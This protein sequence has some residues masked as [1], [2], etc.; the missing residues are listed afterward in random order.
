[1]VVVHPRR[2]GQLMGAGKSL[3]IKNE[4]K[5]AFPLLLDFSSA[6][7]FCL[8]FRLFPAPLTAPVSP[9]KGGCGEYSQLTKKFSIHTYVTL[10]LVSVCLTRCFKVVFLMKLQPHY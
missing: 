10:S 6:E 9:R 5:S 8:L 3:N 7:F 4:R 2:Q 1:M